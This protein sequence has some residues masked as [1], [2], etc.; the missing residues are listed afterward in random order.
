MNDHDAGSINGAHHQNGSSRAIKLVSGC[1]N[2]AK[3][4]APLLPKSDNRILITYSGLAQLGIQYCRLHLRR[5]IEQGSFPAPIQ[6]SPN[7]IAW[8]KAEIDQWLE[9]R[10][11]SR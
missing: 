6:L 11:V 7:R 4:A 3:N 9:N 1:N 5:M 2:K 8:K 10:P